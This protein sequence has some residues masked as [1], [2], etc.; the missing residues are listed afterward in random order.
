MQLH[1]MMNS[2]TVTIYSFNYTAPILRVTYL[3]EFL[4][5]DSQIFY[6]PITTSKQTF[7]LVS[8]SLES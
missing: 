5:M 6:N 1:E 4:W 8:L 7:I 3:K 2:F